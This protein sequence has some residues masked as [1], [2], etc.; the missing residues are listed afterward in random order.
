MTTKRV[1][2]LLWYFAALFN[3]GFAPWAHH[4]TERHREERAH[5]GWQEARKAVFFFSQFGAASKNLKLVATPNV[6]VALCLTDARKTIN[7]SSLLLFCSSLSTCTHGNSSIAM[8]ASLG[9]NL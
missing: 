6:F 7:F 2:P 4:E 1:P 3:L 5:R 9:T 8:L